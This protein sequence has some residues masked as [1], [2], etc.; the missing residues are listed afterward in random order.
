MEVFRLPFLKFLSF[1][2]RRPSLSPIGAGRAFPYMEI[3]CRF[4]P[5]LSLIENRKM[6]AQSTHSIPTHPVVDQS[7]MVERQLADEL[8]TLQQTHVGSGAHSA[9][10]R[11]SWLLSTHRQFHLH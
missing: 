5:I 9:H 6:S 10:D 11:H 2:R 3:S 8:S 7:I 4:R 1:H